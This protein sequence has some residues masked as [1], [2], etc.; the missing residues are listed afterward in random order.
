VPILYLA[1]GDEGVAN[2]VLYYVPN[3][4]AIYTIGVYLASGERELRQGIKAVFSTPLIYAAVL[5]LVLNLTDVTVPRV[6]MRSLDLMGQASVPLM[7]LVLGLNVGRFR[8]SQLGL[9][10]AGAVIRVGGGFALGL[11]AVWLL[12][13]T[14]VPRAVVIFEAAMPGAVAVAVLCS[15]YNTEAELCSSIVLLTTLLAVGV[16][17]V[18]LY[19]LT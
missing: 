11:L 10:V 3:G 13:L 14:G 16:I 5:G 9:T 12:G 8:F 18:L 6:V 19:Y 1:F 15:R 2:A 7:L 17:P 4:L